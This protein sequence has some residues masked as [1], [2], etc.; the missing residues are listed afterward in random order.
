TRL[1]CTLHRQ[2]PGID[3]SKYTEKFAQRMAMAG[4]KPHHRL[5]IAVSGGPDSIAL[6]VL[7]AAWKCNKFN[8]A[9]KQ[10]NKS[11]NGLLAIV[12]DHGLRVESAEEASI[13]YNRVQDMGIKCV[14]VRC[15]WL[16][17]RPKPGHLQE[18]ARN[19]RCLFCL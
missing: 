17:G 4:I 3:L 19:K 8:A 18:A 1:F 14:V 9:D 15:E 16:D 6:C 2:P 5:A 13:V 11:T 7:T 12:V 10:R